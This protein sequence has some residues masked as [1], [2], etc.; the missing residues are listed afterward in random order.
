MS[1]N[2]DGRYHS[3]EQPEETVV[4]ITRGDS[5]EHRPDLNQGML[6]R[7]VAQQAGLPVLMQPLRGKSSDTH[8][9]GE[10]MRPHVQQWQTPSGL[11]SLVAESAL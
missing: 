4:H 11:T 1:S 5:R 2:L 3:D 6:E 10:V 9:F 8:D 7:I